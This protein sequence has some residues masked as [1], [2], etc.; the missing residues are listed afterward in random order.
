MQPVWPRQCSRLKAKGRLCAP[1]KPDS[2]RLC[3]SEFLCA[4]QGFATARSTI[5]R[6]HRRKT[7]RVKSLRT[8]WHRARA[9]R[10]RFENGAD[11]SFDRGVRSRPVLDREAPPSLAWRLLRTQRKAGKVLFRAATAKFSV[12]PRKLRQAYLR[13]RREFRLDYS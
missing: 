10:A 6:P 1:T 2:S 7:R 11:L 13:C 3:R 8:A 12:R 4:N 9:N 5:A